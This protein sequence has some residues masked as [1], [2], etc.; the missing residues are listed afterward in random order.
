SVFGASPDSRC[1]TLSLHDALPISGFHE[2]GMLGYEADEP[3]LEVD[4][5]RWDAGPC[6]YSNPTDGTV[7]GRVRRLGTHSIGGFFPKADV[8]DRK[9]TRLNSSHDQI[10]YAVFCLK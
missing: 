8:L 7:E 4:G 6:I 9:S 5:E 2:F 3:E 10:S 1:Y